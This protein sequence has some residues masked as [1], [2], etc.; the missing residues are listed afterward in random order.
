[1]LRDMYEVT[2][3]LDTVLSVGAAL[4]ME[5]GLNGRYTEVPFKI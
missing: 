5:M 2:L 4:F 3:E 1:M